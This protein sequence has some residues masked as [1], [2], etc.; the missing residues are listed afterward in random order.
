VTLKLLKTLLGVKARGKDVSRISVVSYSE[1]V[2]PGCTDIQSP[3][4]ELEK[5]FNGPNTGLSRGWSL[6][7]IWRGM[8]RRITQFSLENFKDSKTDVTIMTVHD[9]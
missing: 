4:A 1:I 5:V 3:A 9:H 8:V 6:S 7:D 2:F